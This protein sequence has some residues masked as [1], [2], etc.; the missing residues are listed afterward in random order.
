VSIE[1]CEPR[2][3]RAATYRSEKVPEEG[4]LKG[5]ELNA[6]V[7]SA[8]VGI[9]TQHLGRSPRSASSF[10]HENVLVTLMQDVLTVAEKSL[11]R[12]GQADAVSHVRQLFQGVME[13][14]LR[15]AVERLTGRTVLAFIGG[16]HID[17]DVATVVFILDAPL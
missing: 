8:L 2:T 1:S 7:T 16:N 14:D 17:P 4:S 9:H 15:K 12:S 10:Y 3:A 5:G 11:A 6:A 13:A